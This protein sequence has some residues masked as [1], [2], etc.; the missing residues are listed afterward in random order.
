L[1]IAFI[2]KNFSCPKTESF[3][4]ALSQVFASFQTFNLFVEATVPATAWHAVLCGAFLC[5]RMEMDW[6][7]REIDSE[8]DGLSVALALL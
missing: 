8:T 5:K 3:D 2:D 4:F 1:H 6:L 7:L